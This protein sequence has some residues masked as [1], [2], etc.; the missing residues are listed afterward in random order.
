MPSTSGEGA[1]HPWSCA[2]QQHT[3]VMKNIKPYLAALAIVCIW[4][5]WITISRHGVQTILQPADITLLRYGTAL[6]GVAPLIYRHTWHKFKIHQYLVVG[7]GVGFPYTMFSFYGLTQIKAAHA[8]VLVNGMLPVFGAVVAWLLFRQRV[9]FRR[10]VAIAIIF[11]A[12]IVMAGGDTF[13]G[14]HLIG[15]LLFLTAAFLYTLHMT[16]IR[17]W[18]FSWQDVLVTVPVVNVVL[19]LPLWFFLPTALS[20]APL[21]D[22]VVQSLYQ[23]VVVNILALMCV[24]YSIR[25]LGTITVSLYMSF[26]PVTTALL[27]WLL[28]DESLNALELAG[29]AG[30]SAGLVLYAKGWR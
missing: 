11:L 1:V 15:I 6:I 13:R 7:L 21:R 28:L 9:S 26:V 2:G 22:I 20:K 29:I 27:S 19:F 24:A 18:N 12:N 5:G 14:N 30:C 4:S 17:K 3:Y 23:G 25:H 8:G 10:Y 16:G